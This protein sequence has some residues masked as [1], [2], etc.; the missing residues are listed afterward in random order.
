MPIKPVLGTI[1]KELKMKVLYDPPDGWRY[2]FPK[3]VPDVQS[4]DQNIPQETL[5]K[6]LQDANYP[7]RDWDFA[8][9]YGRFIETE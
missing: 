8:L 5:L 3:I 4:L 7:K 9:T 2:G 6:M 1:F